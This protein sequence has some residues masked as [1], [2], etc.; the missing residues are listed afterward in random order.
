M[1]CGYICP[2]LTI[3]REDG[4]INYEGMHQ[5]YDRLIAAGIDGVV[6][7]GSS[8]E[9]Y[10]LPLQACRELAADAISYVKR[11]MKVYIGTGRL[12]LQETVDFSNEMLAAGADAV[13]IVGPY[14]I[15]VD[16][17]EIYE[18]Y[19]EVAARVQGDILLYNYPDRTGYDIPVSVI[20]KLTENHANIIGIKDTHGSAAHTQAMIAAVRKRH[21]AFLI[22]SGF[23]NNFVPVVAAGGDGCI[24]ALSNLVPETCAELTAAMRAEDMERTA[25]AYQ[26]INTLMELY[27]VKAPFMPAMKKALMLQ[28]M[29]ITDVCQ[30]PA[31]PVNEAQTK[32][33]R[34]ILDAAKE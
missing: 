32:R 15:G 22:Y 3:F 5:M 31:K 27:Q 34:E 9:F 1:K 6:V 14:Y 17:E 29:D 25:R 13:I 16:E 28:G 12:I 2:V 18:Y 11:R 20:L 26:K 4:S 21:P 19:H 10:A 33:I 30:T 8:G 23:D 24:A 7:L